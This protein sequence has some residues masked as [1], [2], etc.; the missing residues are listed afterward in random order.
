MRARP[1]F[2]ADLGAFLRATREAKRQHPSD[3]QWSLRGATDIAARKHLADLS[4]QVLFRLE[5][6]QV[7][8]LTREGLVALSQLYD[9]PYREL[10][11]RYIASEYGQAAQSRDLSRQTHELQSPDTKGAPRADLAT[12]RQIANLQAELDRYKQLAAHAKTAARTLAEGFAALEQGARTGKPQ[13][14]LR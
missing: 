9:V 12:T 5:H 3:T 6:G 11:D 1:V 7:R 13:R 14:K 4:Y 8:H 2:H 10:L